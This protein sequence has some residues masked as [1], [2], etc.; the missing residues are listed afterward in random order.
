MLA[1]IGIGI[2]IGI[3]FGFDMYTCTGTRVSECEKGCFKIR[4]TTTTTV[5]ESLSI[6]RRTP[7]L[8]RGCLS[9]C[10]PIYV[11]RQQR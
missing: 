2:G 10:P 7:S 8:G 6:I 1:G 11:S 4:N 5:F 3:G 9:V